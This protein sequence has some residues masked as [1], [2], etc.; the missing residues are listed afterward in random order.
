[1]VADIKYYER[2]KTLEELSRLAFNMDI[3]SVESKRLAWHYKR[4]HTYTDMKL[5]KLLHDFKLEYVFQKANNSTNVE[6]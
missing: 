4:R 3:K 1:M 2:A 5:N 6:T